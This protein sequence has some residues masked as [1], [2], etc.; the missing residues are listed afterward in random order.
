ML[1]TEHL[2]ISKTGEV[3]INCPFYTIFEGKKEALFVQIVCLSVRPAVY[4]SPSK[5][6]KVMTNQ[7][8]AMKAQRGSTGIISLTSASDGVGGQRHAPA[9][10]PPGKENR[11]PF[12]RRL[13]GRQGRSGRAR[14]IPPP[15]GTRSPDRPA[16]NKSLYRLSYP[17]PLISAIKPFKLKYWIFFFKKNLL[18]VT[19]G[20]SIVGN[21]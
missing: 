15:T 2:K 4:M 14:K 17:G 9:A 19:W 18:I 7:E 3:S 13:F 5:T 10:L 1:H 6:V 11:Y 21:S 20:K 12:Y 16:R 8:E